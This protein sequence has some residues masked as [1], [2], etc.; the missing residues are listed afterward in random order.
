[1]QYALGTVRDE[2][3]KIYLL[4]LSPT[5]PTEN[6]KSFESMIKLNSHATTLSINLKMAVNAI[7]FEMIA[8]IGPIIEVA[9][10]ENAANMLFALLFIKKI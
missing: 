8:P 10:I 2:L 4:Q 7:K 1:L 5:E 9:P 3:F 6:P